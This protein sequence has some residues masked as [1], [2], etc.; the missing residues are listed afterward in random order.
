M[1]RNRRSS[2]GKAARDLA[3][4]AGAAAQ[5]FDPGAAGGVGKRGKDPTC[6]SHDL[7]LVAAYHRVNDST[8]S[9]S[10]DW[11]DLIS[12]LPLRRSRAASRASARTVRR[13]HEA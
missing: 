6:V 1:L 3:D 11:V 4:R 2:D 10:W 12:G 8:S 13:L 7:R 5:P 9:L